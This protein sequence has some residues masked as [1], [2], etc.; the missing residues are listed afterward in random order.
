MPLLLHNAQYSSPPEPIAAVPS[1]LTIFA[2][3][4]LVLIEGAL[5]VAVLALVLYRQP[6]SVILRWAIVTAVM[7]V[8]SYLFAQI[9]GA[10]YTDT[11]PFITDHVPPLI[12][13]EA[14]NGFP[15]DHALLA[16]AIVAAV[17]LVRPVWAIPFV[18]LAYLVDWARVGSGL[19]HVG[20][21]VGS[22]VFAAV[23][24]LIALLVAPLVV[25]RLEPHLPARW[26]GTAV[27]SR[28][29]T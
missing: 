1:D 22:S 3:K 8:L 5:A 2:A 15:S 26:G 21:V 29:A 18:V 13:H 23:A 20:D 25:R 17:G 14:D 6:R 28:Q 9:G 11:R 4:Y 12:T 10:V 7:V 16:A 19:H 24:T 27:G